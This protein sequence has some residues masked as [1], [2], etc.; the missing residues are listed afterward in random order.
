MKAL[1]VSVFVS[2]ETVRITA[3][4]TT[5]DKSKKADG[6][7][8]KKTKQWTKIALRLPVSELVSKI[9]FKCLQ[10]NIHKVEA[11]QAVGV[12]P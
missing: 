9:F 1:S 2:V 5:T 3:I 6:K 10:D 7:P 12:L 11:F 4:F 8:R